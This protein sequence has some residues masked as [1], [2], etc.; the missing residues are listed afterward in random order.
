MRNISESQKFWPRLCSLF[1]VKYVSTL[2][3]VLIAL[4]ALLTACQR[5]NLSNS[6]TPEELITNPIYS[7]QVNEIN[8]TRIA[9]GK[10]TVE[11]LVEKGALSREPRKPI[12]SQEDFEARKR[13]VVEIPTEGLSIEENDKRVE[14]GIMF[15][16]ATNG[17]IRVEE[18]FV[19]PEFE[20]ETEDE[21]GTDTETPLEVDIVIDSTQSEPTDQSS[22][23]SAPTEAAPPIKT[24][25]ATS[26]AVTIDADNNPAGAIGEDNNPPSAEEAEGESSVEDDSEEGSE[27]VTIEIET[28]PRPVARPSADRP[29]EEPS[30]DP[31]AV[32]PVPRPDQTDPLPTVDL[33]MP[34]YFDS[35]YQAR[36]DS[37]AVGPKYTE[38]TL[39]ALDKYGPNLLDPDFDLISDNG[40]CEN[41]N[42]LNLEDRRRFWLFLASA[43]VEKESGFDTFSDYQEDNGR[44]SRGL[45][46]FGYYQFP[47]VYNCGFTHE[48]ELETNPKKNIECGIK[49]MNYWITLD[50]TMR[51]YNYSTK[52]VRGLAQYWGAL[53]FEHWY[54]TSRDHYYSNIQI[55]TRA[56]NLPFCKKS[57]AVESSPR[58]IARPSDDDAGLMM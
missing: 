29:A 32:R 54:N 52:Y 34:N 19:E 44:Y 10:P 25:P 50:K 58:P 1:G 38:Y 43:I 51:V 20:T 18:F 3:I 53:R 56:S 27:S 37:Y 42:D 46:Q 4:I 5:Q 13:I 39:N 55:Q 6:P 23:A 49:V 11:E 24:D 33:S 16:E 15:P 48:M 9:E 2:K 17:R 14:E 28:S 40:M 26:G 47:K 21:D 45:F 22:N 36:W 8:R 30:S 7:D 41:Y 57:L 31:S 35:S 12:T